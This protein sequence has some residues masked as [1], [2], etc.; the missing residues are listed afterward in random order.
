MTGRVSKPKATLQRLWTDRRGAIAPMVAVS[1]IPLLISV[2][3]AV[4]VGR[5]VSSRSQLQDATDAANLALARMPAS[6]P[7]AALQAKAKEWILANVT[8]PA[9]RSSLVVDPP[10]RVIGEIKLTANG[11]MATSFS[12]LL[13][14]ST[15]QVYGASTVKYGTS[16][17]ELA[18]VLDN[19]GSMAA[20]GKLQALKDAAS[21]LVDTL[22]ASALASGDA[23]ALKIGVVPFSM[24]VN[25][26][27][28]YQN[29]SW[30]SGAMPAA[31]GVDADAVD[32]SHPNRFT[33]F[34]KVNRTWGGCVESRPK[35]YDVSDAPPV[36]GASLFVPFFAPDEPDA[37]YYKYGSNIY[38]HYSNDGSHVT[39][40]NDYL[41]DDYTADTTGATNNIT[42]S[43]V[44]STHYLERQTNLSKY[45]TSPRTG[46]NST[47]PFWGDAVGPNSGCRIAPLLRLT[48]DMT[49][50]RSKLNEMIATGDTEIPLGLV[51]G[52]HLLSPNGPFA[53]GSAYGAKGKIKIIVL[54]TDGDNTYGTSNNLN[55]S[56]YTAY[57]YARQKRISSTGTAAATADALDSR[58]AVLCSNL[59]AKNPD[60]TQKVIVYTVPVGVADG[61]TKS[62]LQTCATKPENFIDVAGASGIKDAFNDIAGKIAGLRVAH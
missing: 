22:E 31:Y 18:L 45:K 35:D 8:D 23:E 51:W 17:I 1:L 52:W 41:N 50:V 21:K 47:N 60:D 32:D 36:A 40:N 14:V 37:G 19:T 39:W 57:A 30:I 42:R 55:L 44:G 62:A 38:M 29:A 49:A 16:H 2:G 24:T 5:L 15:M 7:T 3:V 48:K 13:G 54:V 27:S 46:A 12:G 34:Q 58:L 59:K 11:Q 25:V 61:A 10:Q 53:D 43:N 28:Q 26:G 33:L 4:D 9:I 56:N 6:T 20:D